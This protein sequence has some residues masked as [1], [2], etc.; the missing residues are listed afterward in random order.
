MS[1]AFK[2]SHPLKETGAHQLLE[3][4]L[5]KHGELKESQSLQWLDS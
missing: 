2:S 1:E 5:R 3:S 4:E